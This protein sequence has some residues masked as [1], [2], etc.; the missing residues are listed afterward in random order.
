MTP[1]ATRFEPRHS[2]VMRG[3]GRGGG[4]CNTEPSDAENTPPWHGQKRTFS[5][6]L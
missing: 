4:A 3:S 5:S 2:I 6:G 1:V